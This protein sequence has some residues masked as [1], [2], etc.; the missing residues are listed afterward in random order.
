MK[1]TIT[2]TALLLFSLL[3][4]SEVFARTFVTIGSGGGTG[5]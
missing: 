1:R 4:V 3:L 2:F 5:V